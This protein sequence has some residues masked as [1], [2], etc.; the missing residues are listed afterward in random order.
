MGIS[1]EEAEIALENIDHPDPEL[2]LDWI[3]ANMERMGELLTRRIMEKSKQ[4][5]ENVPRKAEI[6]EK[7][8]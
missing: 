3:Q 1:R 5:S 6:P 8:K 2:A 4:E 7:G